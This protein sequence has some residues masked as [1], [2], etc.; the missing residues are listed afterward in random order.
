M[1]ATREEFKQSVNEVLWEMWSEPI[2]GFKVAYMID[3]ILDDV[4][5]ELL[6]QNEVAYSYADIDIATQKVL[7]R[8]LGIKEGRE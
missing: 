8:R 3:A 2:F 7:M 1:K 6:I 5:D 4:V